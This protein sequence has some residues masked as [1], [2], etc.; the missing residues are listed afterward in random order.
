[1]N[2]AFLVDIALCY[3][4]MIRCASGKESDW[5]LDTRKY[6]VPVVVTSTCSAPKQSRVVPQCSPL[7]TVRTFEPHHRTKTIVYI[8]NVTSGTALLSDTRR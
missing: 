6:M 8:Q 1:M 2:A 7:F 4:K 3:K 5:P